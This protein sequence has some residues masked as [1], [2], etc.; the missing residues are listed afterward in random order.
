M[1][2]DN[3]GEVGIWWFYNGDLIKS[4]IP[5]TEGVE[6]GDFINGLTDHY[7]FL[8][9]VRM[10]YNRV[11]S[12][13]EYEE[14]PRGRVVYNKT[15]ETFVVYTSARLIKDKNLRSL[16]LRK[17]KLPATATQ[18]IQDAHYENLYKTEDSRGMPW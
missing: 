6:Y 12:G 10:Y 15:T 16:V 3:I 7:P 13:Y 5:L 9:R 2:E 17:F 4:S 11:L 18:F 14:I 8:E 1:S